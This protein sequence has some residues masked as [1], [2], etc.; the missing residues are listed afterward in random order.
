[1]I[2]L[3][4]LVNQP[5]VSFWAMLGSTTASRHAAGAVARPRLGSSWIKLCVCELRPWMFPGCHKHD[6]RM[7]PF[8]VDWV[9]ADM[10][11]ADVL[12]MVSGD[13]GRSI[14]RV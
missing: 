10:E 3:Q 12:E 11:L 9:F 8:S 1:M 14:L 6:G 5:R 2:D 7:A 13:H 4:G